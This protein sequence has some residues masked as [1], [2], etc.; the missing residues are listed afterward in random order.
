[1]PY[2][3][4]TGGGSLEPSHKPPNESLHLVLQF[5]YILGICLVME[6]I[7]GIV[8]LIFRNQVGLWV[9]HRPY[10]Y[11]DPSGYA[12]GCTQG[13]AVGRVDRWFS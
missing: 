2:Y 4:S 12:L 7:G 8:A 13:A 10:V 1:V 9:H 6:L 11:Q 3:L 5:M